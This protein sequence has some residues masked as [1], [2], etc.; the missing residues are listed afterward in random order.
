MR[1]R[2][3][4]LKCRYSKKGN[5]KNAR[6]SQKVSNSVWLYNTPSRKVS[7]SLFS[8]ISSQKI[9]LNYGNKRQCIM[10]RDV[11]RKSFKF[12]GLNAKGTVL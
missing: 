7:D 12:W 9:D 2:E 1:S 11:T 3:R 6:T 4:A 10:E 8:L 5:R